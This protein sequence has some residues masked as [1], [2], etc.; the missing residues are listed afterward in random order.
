MTPIHKSTN[1]NDW[2][3]LGELC[4][5]IQEKSVHAQVLAHNL[6]PIPDCKYIDKTAS[7]ISAFKCHAENVMFVRLEYGQIKDC[8]NVNL[9]NI[10][11]G[12]PIKK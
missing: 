5:E 6:M 2:M 12:R 11:Y 7:N 3:K 10:F 4:K 9:I 8:E 1:F